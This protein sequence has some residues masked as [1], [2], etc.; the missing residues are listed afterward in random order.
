MSTQTRGDLELQRI[1]LTEKINALSISLEESKQNKSD[2]ISRFNEIELQIE[3]RQKLVKTINKE[4]KLINTDVQATQD[5][6]EETDD[7]LETL[8]DEFSVLLHK[9]YL[10][11]LRNKNKHAL[12]SAHSIKEAFTRW[13]YIKQFESFLTSKIQSISNLQNNLTEADSLIIKTK[14]TQEELLE[15]EKINLASLENEQEELNRLL[16]EK[17]S[18]QVQM[19]QDLESSKSQK[20]RLNKLIEKT[21]LSTISN[22]EYS[23]ISI[24]KGFEY[25]R[26]FLNPPVRNGKIVLRYGEQQH[27][28]LKNVTINNS[29]I[30]IKS[31]VKDVFAIM[32]GQIISVT[33]INTNQTTIIIQHDNDYY[34]VYSNL[35]TAYLNKGAFV[36]TDQI[37]GELNQ[38]DNND[39]QIHFEVWRAKENLNPTHWIK[40]N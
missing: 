18:E 1:Q 20:S 33:K 31:K 4:L 39:Y 14:I 22:N 35:K 30:D 15:L 16:L 6:K 37:L 5:K 3:A 21:F 2:L 32:E 13:K 26:G 10:D 19:S 36:N 11:R 25:K 23:S 27:P 28:T 8:I 24:N 12:L 7:N 40:N 9:A 17:Q 38:A 34:S 29:G